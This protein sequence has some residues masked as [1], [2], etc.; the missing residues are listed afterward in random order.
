MHPKIKPPD[1]G[2]EVDKRAL[3]AGRRCILEMCAGPILVRK[4]ED[5][6][7]FLL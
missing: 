1:L 5:K 3:A 6:L 2:S 7:V 4:L